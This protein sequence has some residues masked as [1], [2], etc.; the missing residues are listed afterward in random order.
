MYAEF[1]AGIKQYIDDT[2]ERGGC[3]GMSWTL[4]SLLMQNEMLLYLAEDVVEVAGSV[5]E[6]GTTLGRDAG[7]DRYFLG[8]ENGS[9]QV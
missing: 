8:E 7:G 4:A 1:L 6:S 5:R 9:V 3:I 2:A